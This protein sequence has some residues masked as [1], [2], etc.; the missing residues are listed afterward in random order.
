VYCRGE[1]TA[2]CNARRLVQQ[3]V[4][5]CMEEGTLELKTLYRKAI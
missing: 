5:Y 4:Q 1:G 3:N 2:E